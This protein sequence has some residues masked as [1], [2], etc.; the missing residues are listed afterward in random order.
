MLFYQ[1]QSMNYPAHKNIKCD[2][3]VKKKKNSATIS[4]TDDQTCMA[5]RSGILKAVKTNARP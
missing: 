3:V 2:T 4:T 5:L 1:I